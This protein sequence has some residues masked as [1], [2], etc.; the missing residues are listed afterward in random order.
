MNVFLVKRSEISTVFSS[1]YNI[2]HKELNKYSR[3]FSFTSYK[4]RK[5]FNE[6]TRKFENIFPLI[7]SQ[8]NLENAWHEIKSKPSKDNIIIRNNSEILDDLGQDWF[9]KISIALKLGT[10]QYSSARRMSVYKFGKINTKRFII[11]ILG[12][13]VVQKAFLR[14]LQ[15]IYEGVTIWKTVNKKKEYEEYKNLF[16]VPG[17]KIK[18]I[19]KEKNKKI[20]KIRKWIIEPR[21]YEYSYGFRLNRSAHMALKTIKKK[22][23]PTWF[24]SIDIIKVFDKVNHHRL[25]NE[26]SKTIDDPKI[27][28]ELWKMLNLKSVNLKVSATTWEEKTLPGNVLSPFLFNVYMTPLDNFICDLY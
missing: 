22:W 25:I 6:K 18:K 9:K 23:R 12:N 13:K 26:I 21:F 3:C 10:H 28:R 16:Y 2:R 14:I 4:L 27:I 17:V 19:E 20:Y 8:K 15:Q 1:G 7:Y 11:E 24:W 5:K